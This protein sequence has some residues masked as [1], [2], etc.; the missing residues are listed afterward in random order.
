VIRER[1]LEHDFEKQRFDAITFWAV[2]EHLAEPKHSS[3]RCGNLN[4][5]AIVLFWCRTCA[6]WRFGSSA[7]VSL[8]HAGTFEL[9]T[10]RTLLRF[11]GTE[12][13]FQARIAQHAFQPAGD[14]Q[15]LKSAAI[16]S[17]RPGVRA[18]EENDCYETKQVALRSENPLSHMR[19]NSEAFLSRRQFSA[20]AAAQ[21]A[22]NA[23]G[24]CR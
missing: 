7:P 23:S 8:H 9:L 14:S 19:N 21:P 5:A 17:I 13:R 15:D 24:D 2:M 1:F 3:A 10:T 11:A 12:S 20:G 6:R 16:R 22:P 4:L 18:F